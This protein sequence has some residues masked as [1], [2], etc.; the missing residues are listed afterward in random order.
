L[1][2][3][4][5]TQEQF[6]TEIQQSLRC[7]RSEL[8]NMKETQE[9]PK[10][11]HELENPTQV[12]GATEDIRGASSHSRNTIRNCPRKPLKIIRS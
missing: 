3:L 4:Q 1:E 2:Q 12:L 5:V 7:V 11:R 6:S 9:E 8:K 10:L